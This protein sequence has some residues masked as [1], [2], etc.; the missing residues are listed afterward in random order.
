MTNI[1]ITPCLIS[2]LGIL[3]FYWLSTSLKRKYK[4]LA[5]SLAHERVQ[6]LFSLQNQLIAHWPFSVLF[7]DVTVLLHSVSVHL[8]FLLSANLF[9]LVLP[10]DNAFSFND[11]LLGEV[12]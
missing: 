5:L 12:L 10:K 9:P 11:L 2:G 1:Y 6:A 7:N 8:F 3:L 4:L